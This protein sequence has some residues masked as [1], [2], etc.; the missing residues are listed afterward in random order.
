MIIIFVCNTT[1]CLKLHLT[2]ILQQQRLTLW[3]KAKLQT[4]RLFTQD[5]QIWDTHS[6]IWQLFDRNTA[7]L[8]ASANCQS[9][10]HY[11]VPVRYSSLFSVILTLFYELYCNI[12]KVAWFLESYS[13]CNYALMSLN[14]CYFF[15]FQSASSSLLCF[16][17]YHELFCW[18]WVDYFDCFRK[19]AET[20]NHPKMPSTSLL[21]HHHCHWVHQWGTRLHEEALGLSQNWTPASNTNWP[22]SIFCTNQSN[23]VPNAFLLE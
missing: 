3:K 18:N 9:N 20:S 10:K 13:N 1:I 2:F 22:C 8:S 11:A 19:C 23:L 21:P 15:L 16:T 7:A 17:G 6:L 14:P 5:I 12:W 4:S